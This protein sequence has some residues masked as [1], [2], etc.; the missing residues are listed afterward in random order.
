MVNLNSKGAPKYLSDSKIRTL[1]NVVRRRKAKELF[2]KQFQKSRRLQV[3]YALT[4]K[5]DE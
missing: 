2:F 4:M 1:S 5:N 3:N